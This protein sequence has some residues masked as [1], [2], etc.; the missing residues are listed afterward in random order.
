[1]KKLVL[2]AVLGITAPALA[3]TGATPRNDVNMGVP[4]CVSNGTCPALRAAMIRQ[5]SPAA[6]LPE[7]A[8][9]GPFVPAQAAAPAMVPARATTDYPVCRTPGQDRCIQRGGRR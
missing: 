2:L 1:M 6:P 8:T 9:G 5:L 3:Q 4:A 7:A